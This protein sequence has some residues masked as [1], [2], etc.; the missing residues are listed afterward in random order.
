M[1]EG[2]ELHDAEFDSH[3]ANVD[4]LA[5]IKHKMK[6]FKANNSKLTQHELQ[7]FELKEVEKES[8]K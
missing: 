5:K 7:L 8:N 2:E 3:S 4:A 1:N 6:R